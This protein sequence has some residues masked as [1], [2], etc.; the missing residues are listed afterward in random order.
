MGGLLASRNLGQV[1]KDLGQR[2]ESD[3]ET[4]SYVRK[5]FSSSQISVLFA[6]SLPWVAGRTDSG[7]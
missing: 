4:L 6:A 7:A 1:G 3:P 2:A 5:A